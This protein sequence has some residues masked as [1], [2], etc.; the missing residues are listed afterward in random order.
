M[1]MKN[2]VVGEMVK[3]KGITDSN[4][5]Y[6]GIVGVVLLPKKESAQIKATNIGILEVPLENLVRVKQQWVEVEE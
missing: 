2:P 1:A 6:N 5:C 3:V 4:S